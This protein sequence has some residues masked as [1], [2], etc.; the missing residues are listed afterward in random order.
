MA[1]IV[2]SLMSVVQPAPPG[3]RVGPPGRAAVTP[4]GQ[5]RP[6]ARAQQPRGPRQYGAQPRLSPALRRSAQHM[7][8]R[9]R[10]PGRPTPQRRKPLRLRRRRRQSNGRSNGSAMEAASSV[11]QSRCSLGAGPRVGCSSA[12]TTWPCRRG[13]R[14][15]ST[16]RSRASAMR[17][18]A[19]SWPASAAVTVDPGG[20]TWSGS[21]WH[22]AAAGKARLL[23]HPT[24][25]KVPGAARNAE[26]EHET[27]QSSNFPWNART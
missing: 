21:G 6:G 7:C 5:A 10:S 3:L 24:V 15:G 2:S 27:S 4:A 14:A 26:A 12:A 23:R 1:E 8:R 17:P 18:R 9:R 22:F 13:F 20:E 25:A 16:G 19:S 11:H